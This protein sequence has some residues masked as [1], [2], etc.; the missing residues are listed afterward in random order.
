MNHRTGAPPTSAVYTRVTA[1]MIQSEYRNI[2]HPDT[3]TYH[4]YKAC[5]PALVLARTVHHISYYTGPLTD[6][7]P[8][9]LSPICEVVTLIPVLPV[10]P[11]M[12]RWET[13]VC[14]NKE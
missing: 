11:S 7:G 9:D 3:R 14:V 13:S 12:L 2:Y 8:N 5:A 10:I 1:V 6:P 4:R